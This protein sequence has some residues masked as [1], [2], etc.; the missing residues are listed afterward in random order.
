[1]YFSARLVSYCGTGVTLE[2]G[3]NGRSRHKSAALASTAAWCHRVT[4]FQMRG[5][6]LTAVYKERKAKTDHNQLVCWQKNTLTA[7]KCLALARTSTASV[8]PS[9]GTNLTLLIARKR[10]PTYSKMSTR[11]SCSNFLSGL[12]TSKRWRECA[13]STTSVRTLRDPL[14]HWW[15]YKNKERT[16]SSISQ[17]CPG[18]PWNSAEW[19]QMFLALIEWIA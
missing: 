14:K 17:G 7:R 8:P 18:S 3:S 13:A 15:L 6:P 2:L 12:G 9:M 19:R 1:M 5:I 16:G 10:L 11:M 4:N